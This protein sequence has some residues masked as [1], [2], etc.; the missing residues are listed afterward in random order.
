MRSAFQLLRI[1]KSEN[2]T[3]R[4][5]EFHPEIEPDNGQLETICDAL[6]IKIRRQQTLE[7]GDVLV[8]IE[9]GSRVL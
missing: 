3:E 9:N 1:L 5:L 4:V 2:L 7:F 8:V 6:N